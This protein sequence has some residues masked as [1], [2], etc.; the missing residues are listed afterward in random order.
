M[1]NNEFF[2]TILESI[3]KLAHI[4][5]HYKEIAKKN[6]IL[7]NISIGIFSAERTHVETFCAALGLF[8]KE[9]LSYGKTQKGFVLFSTFISD[10]KNEPLMP[11][12][13]V[14]EEHRFLNELLAMGCL[15]YG[16][17]L[18]DIES[19]NTTDVPPAAA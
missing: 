17:L 14:T 15:L 10:L 3:E 2:L 4:D 16:R 19:K 8:I 9:T 5:P 1:T 13:Y 11:Q 12:L 7:E 18:T 6:R